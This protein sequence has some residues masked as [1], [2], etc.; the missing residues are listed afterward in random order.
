MALS[1]QG[2]AGRKGKMAERREDNDNFGVPYKLVNGKKIY[3]KKVIRKGGFADSYKYT[4]P[5]TEEQQEG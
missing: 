2:Y 1:R 4:Y 3:A 5:E